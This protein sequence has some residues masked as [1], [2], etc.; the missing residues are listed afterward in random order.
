MQPTPLFG[1][2]AVIES[3][4]ALLLDERMR[5][6]TLTGTGGVGKTRLALAV[7][8]QLRVCFADGVRFVPLEAVCDPRDIA[9]A[10]VSAL[11]LR[12]TTGEPPEQTL[13][14]FFGHRETLL[15]LDNFEHLLSAATLVSDLLTACP[16]LAILVTSR[17]PLSLRWEHEVFVP[18]LAL[19]PAAATRPAAGHTTASFESGAFVQTAAS[20]AVQLFVHRAQAVA[21]GFRLGVH[22]AAA[23]AA[24]CARLDGL[25]L[26]IELA[27]MRIKLFTPAALLERLDRRLALLTTAPRDVPP[28]HR[29]LR[30]TVS[31]SHDLLTPDEQAL[32]RRLAVFAG[33][34]TSE[35]IEAI[36]SASPALATPWEDLAATLVDHSLLRRDD[37]PATPPSRH[38]PQLR[39][40]ET[41]RE[42]ALEQLAEQGEEPAMRR[43]HADYYL[44]LAGAA[45][46]KLAGP[47]QGAW[48][49]RLESEHDNLR[50]ALYWTIEAGE[51][52]LAGRLCAALGR[53]WLIRGHQSEGRRWLARVLGPSPGRSS[54]R[55]QDAPIQLSPATTESVNLHALPTS[56]RARVLT[57]AAAL[58]LSQGAFE[59]AG[60]LQ[61]EGL[62]LWQQLEDQHGIA[63]A[64]NTL[65]RL[66][67]RRSDHA[68]ARA[69]F[70]ECLTLRREI[71]DHVGVATT[72]NSLG[73]SAMQCGEHARAQSLFEESVSL[74]RACGDHFST[75]LALNNLG[76]LHG[77]RQDLAAARALF[78]EA[79][80]L[81]RAIGDR[82]WIASSLHN[83]AATAMN[84]GDYTTA[85]GLYLESLTL[86]ADLGRLL[87]VAYHLEGLAT[88]TAAEGQA[89]R[90]LRIFGAAEALRVSLGAPLPSSDAAEQE[91][92]I[93]G[94]RDELSEAAAQ[95]AWTAG[96]AMSVS[97][98]IA[99][100]TA[101]TAQSA[102]DAASGTV[103][104]PTTGSPLSARGS[105]VPDRLTPREREVLR[106]LAAGRT[107]QEMADELVLSTHTIARHI[108][109]LYAK[110]GARGRADATAYALRTGLA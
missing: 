107:N 77:S 45:E 68:T 24:I 90:A 50:A 60:A 43:R 66:A 80:T 105:N 21:P 96:Q 83:L 2:D 27:S 89:D 28:R 54:A 17:A 65:G 41:V 67:L 94:I 8:A 95:S 91:R 61:A 97:R 30:A 87:G 39:M 76:I 34:I 93:A 84:Q 106:L 51:M 70:D 75:A 29:A 72:L 19:P 57:S 16:N 99:Y 18:P 46:A 103:A 20:P 9:V 79:L 44:Q 22:N 12:G 55:P 74:A 31:W 48:L 108:A 56:V 23:V 38:E 85:R 102:P 47:D 26:A 5:L 37:D 64:L 49:E 101:G 69:L 53:F 35:G 110:I 52:E 10:I 73:L 15:V 92:T 4:R 86:A 40:L 11:S 109:N 6:V 32:F 13:R 100:A 25:P 78:E 71:G 98:A 63:D 14:R 58:A 82:E 59:E 3:A 7:A 36:S 88:I 42:Y 104:E 33:G 62:R 1:R 81:R